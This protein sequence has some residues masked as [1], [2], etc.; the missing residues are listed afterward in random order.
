MQKHS[1]LD[2]DGF[3]HE[4]QVSL[5]MGYR[6]GFLYWFGV[7]DHILII[8]DDRLCSSPQ[9]KLVLGPLKSAV[10]GDEP[11][12]R[13]P[14]IWDIISG[15]SLHGSTSVGSIQLSGNPKKDVKRYFRGDAWWCVPELKQLANVSLGAMPLKN[16][17]MAAAPPFFC[18]SQE[19]F[20]LLVLFVKP[21]SFIATLWWFNVADWKIAIL[22]GQI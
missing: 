1:F 7:F 17:P 5:G 19:L 14:E 22:N 6:L 16:R 21:A 8:L 3:C 13:D 4:D 2:L 9:R 11:F 20:H 15:S 12:E 10:A 18:Q